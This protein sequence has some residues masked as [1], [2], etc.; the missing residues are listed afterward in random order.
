MWLALCA[1]LAIV[2]FFLS[3][4][5]NLQDWVLHRSAI[6][7]S[8]VLGSL[9]A[10][11]SAAAML[12]ATELSPG[13]FF[14]LRV[15]TVATA[16]ML[17]GPVAG[18]IAAVATAFIR[19]AMGGAGAIA[20]VVTVGLSLAAGLVGYRMWGRRRPTL[21]ATVLV[22]LLV[23]ST[24]LLGTLLLPEAVR[25][26]V[27][28]N[29]GLA[30]LVLTFAATVAAVT[31]VTLHSKRAAERAL[32][33]GAIA[34]APD[35]FYIKSTSGRFVAVNRNVAA[36]SGVATPDLLKGQT[37][38]D[39]T[40]AERADALWAEEQ[41]VMTSGEALLDKHETLVVAGAEPRHFVTSKSAVRLD[42]GV[43]V[44]LVGVSR[45][46]TGA[47]NA[48]TELEE[49]RDQLSFILQ[50]MSDGVALVSLE[51]Y[52]ILTNQ[53]YR[54]LFPRPGK[55]RVAGSYY[56]DVLQQVVDSGE[57]PDVAR[58][59]GERW[60]AELMATLRQGG[61][62][63]VRLYDNQWL[64]IRTKVHAR[65]L[66]TIVVSDITA[67]KRAETD[68][69]ALTR[70][71][72][73]QAATDGLTH[74]LN[75]RGFDE[76]IEREM[77]RAA[78]TGAPVSVVMIDVDHFKAYNDKYGHL[79]GDECL[80]AVAAVLRAAATR[81]IDV[82]A[83]YGGEEFAMLLS[84]T[85]AAGAYHVAEQVRLG[86]LEQRIRHEA[87]ELGCLTVSLGV[88]TLAGSDPELS[89]KLLLGRADEALYLAKDGGR[90]RTEVYASGK[91]VLASGTGS[92]A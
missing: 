14:D 49:S 66:S 13:V 71:L 29:A 3:I 88:A 84:D 2:G 12:F 50:E 10:V 18:L 5:A 36:I 80:K 76:A 79:A 91:P 6:V 37:D 45:D 39:V 9:M 72:E 64:R 69:L 28:A 48:E 46:V 62:E 67:L 19:L 58:G 51:G 38:H 4:W 8:V 15:T 82:V 89:P 54:D 34:Q 25:A 43:I 27:W 78:R 87:S 60:I 30:I 42:S 41:H 73:L 56:P 11:A 83:R 26:S 59:S 7:H 47:R 22:S 23:A 68:L 24:P 86:V 74:V 20:G 16:A 61:E 57:Q 75:R 81:P 40:E 33:L 17:G 21:G 31:V 53:R 90:D 44:G 77:A 65:G 85:D 52:F 92:A 55:L 70:Q 35:Y 1:N 63:I 32:L